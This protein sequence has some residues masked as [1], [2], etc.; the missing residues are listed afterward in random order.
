MIYLPSIKPSITPYKPE[1]LYRA[2]GSATEGVKTCE[3]LQE[4]C[5]WWLVAHSKQ[6][7]LVLMFFH[8]GNLN[9][10]CSTFPRS[11]STLCS[12]VC[13]WA[14]RRRDCRTSQQVEKHHILNLKL[15]TKYWYGITHKISHPNTAVERY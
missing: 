15:D 11:S 2:V 6:K 5:L 4:H 8:Q 14:P 3:S 10:W 1:S 13:R 7:L 12:I 9:L